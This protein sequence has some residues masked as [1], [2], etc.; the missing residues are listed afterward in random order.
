MRDL[1]KN[2]HAILMRSKDLNKDQTYFLHEVSGAEF[3]KCMFPLEDLPKFEVREIAEKN[4]FI[5]L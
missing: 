5:N 4:N 3:A 1:H 2:D